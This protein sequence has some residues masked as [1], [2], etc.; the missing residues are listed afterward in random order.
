MPIVKLSRETIDRICAGEVVERPFSV[1]KELVE[2]SIDAHA[3]RIE[4]DIEEGGRKLV[5]VGDDGLG[6]P[7]SEVALSLER[8]TTSKIRSDEDLSS[9]KTL[10][11]RGEA[12]P[13]MAAVTRISIAS[14]T[15][16]QEYG[17]E[18]GCEGGMLTGEEKVVINPGTIVT[19]RDLFFNVPA[20]RKFLRS[21]EAELNLVSGLIASYSL[22]YPDVSFVLR[23]SGRTVYESRGDGDYDRILKAL[24]GE[25]AAKD[26]VGIDAESHNIHLTGFAA[27]PHHHRNNRNSQYYF[28]NRRL[29]RNRVFLKG[30]DEA[31]REY[32][33][34]GK[35]P[36]LALFYEV[37][38]ET[39][40]VNVH[41]TKMEINFANAN[42][43]FYIT[44]YGIR[45]SLEKSAKAVQDELRSR[46]AWSLSSEGVSQQDQSS[47]PN[48]L[49]N[50]PSGIGT[51]EPGVVGIFGN[52]AT[53]SYFKPKP[54]AQP[55][56]LLETP[57]GEEVGGDME[58]A[59]QPPPSKLSAAPLAMELEQAEEDKIKI[60]GTIAETFI[61]FV[62]GDELYI[63]DQH[64]SHE[65]II[66]EDL[67]NFLNL[68]DEVPVDKEISTVE[69]SSATGSG[70]GEAE[71][72]K[73]GALPKKVESQELLF[74]V[75]LSFTPAQIE[76]IAKYLDP[77]RSLGI[78]AEVFGE[79]SI[80]V[81]SVPVLLT[82][83]I[84][85]IVARAILEDLIALDKRMTL[86]RM[87]K[88]LAAQIACRSAVKAHDHL[89][90]RE[91]MY[92]FQR[93]L[94]IRDSST[95]PHGRPTILRMGI[96][97]LK[98]LFQR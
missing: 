26:T 12:L 84:N 57:V 53:Y 89:S 80:L 73:E 68:E 16:D 79:D 41:P 75:V 30:V 40:D 74:P 47:E 67:Y 45:T 24:F 61:L 97:D 22:A 5:K 46:V 48:L 76:L 32:L 1:V 34:T 81:R 83:R 7:A 15:R 23:S 42:E 59:G 70:G 2:N 28:V 91:K 51:V 88:D 36:I 50:P 13:S 66:Y 9:L 78:G 11:F 96:E 58:R 6:I 10:G 65:R 98:R 63:M 44:Q 86:K 18:I 52:K 8:H 31:Y 38:P 17:M 25:E 87:M 35:Q 49:R 90:N 92:L 39:I 19:V 29:V 93:L 4:V 94:K 55:T 3:K 60:L 20:R 72:A 43:V 77:V 21:R 27:R 82:G 33:S 56:G 54:V 69:Y 37:N 14:R 64:S 71:S 95:C 85:P 62:T